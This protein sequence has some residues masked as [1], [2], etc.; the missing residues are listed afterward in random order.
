MALLVRQQKYSNIL[1]FHS[2]QHHSVTTSDSLQHRL[3]NSE[4]NAHDKQTNDTVKIARFELMTHVDT[5]HFCKYM[6]IDF[7][8]PR[9]QLNITIFTLAKYVIVNSPLSDNSS[10]V[11]GCNKYAYC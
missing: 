1:N 2:A 7:I 9:Q 11:V 4:H 10:S 5:K 3:C 8:A 6:N